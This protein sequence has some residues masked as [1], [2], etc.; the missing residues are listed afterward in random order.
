[1]AIGQSSVANAANTVSV[2]SA[3]NARRIVNVADG[4]NPTDAVNL[5]QLQALLSGQAP[6]AGATGTV[7]HGQF[8]ALLPAASAS[9]APRPAVVDSNSRLIDIER[10]LADLQALVQRQQER[11]AELENRRAT[12]TRAE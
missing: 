6:A 3:G 11:I 9:A 1:V 12:A 10:K 7:S 4:I 8:E 5:G 2:G